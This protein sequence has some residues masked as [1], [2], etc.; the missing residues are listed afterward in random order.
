MAIRVYQEGEH[1]SGFVGIR[2]TRSFGGKY[3]QTYFSFR[4]SGSV[5]PAK[6]QKVLLQQAQA[7]EEQW[8]A[9]SI[10]AR[11]ESRLT[12]A[13]PNTKPHRSVGVEGITAEFA[14]DNA[15]PDRVYYYPGFRVSQPGVKS[16][17]ARHIRFSLHGYTGA[18]QLAVEMW[19][20]RYNILPKDKKRV[21]KNM[22][23][24]NQF[25][26]LRRQMNKEGH[27]IPTTALSTVFAEQRKA[28]AS[29]KGVKGAPLPPR[30][31]AAVKTLEKSLQNE[32]QKF[33]RK[34]AIKG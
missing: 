6:E 29:G 27:E 28:V 26:A 4:K 20:E 21:L 16:G 14:V 24:P 13:H 33:T 25:V 31:A 34:K 7:L 32:V 5:I 8:K 23:D 12:S 17:A 2:V 9:E 30:K 18:W 15:G 1:P 22:P 3:R 11:Y 10:Q 19:A